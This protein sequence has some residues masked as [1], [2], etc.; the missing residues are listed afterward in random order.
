MQNNNEQQRIAIVGS[1]I[2]GL[3]CGYLLSQ[4]H[5]ITLFEANDYLGGHTHTYDVESNGKTYPVNTGFIVFNDWTYPNFIKLMDKLGVESEESDMSFS[6]RDENSGLE[7]NGTSLNSLFAQRI[8]IIRPRFL[9][10]VRDILRFNKETVSALSQQ[11]I[12]EGQTL[13]EFVEEQGYG[14]EF[15]HH[16]IVPMGSAIWSASVD[17]MMDFPLKFFLQ[18][19]NNHGML[20]VDDRPTWRVLTGGS[21]SYIDPITAPFKERIH[22]NTPVTS[23]KRHDTGVTI[24]TNQGTHEFDQVIFACHSDQALSMLSDASMDEEHILGTI[25]YQMNDVV[26]HT[27]ERLMP[28]RKLAWAAWNYHIPQRK[29][30][31]AMVTYNMNILQ[32]YQDAD[33]TFLVTLNRNQEIDPDK[34]IA[35]FRYAHPVFTLDGVASQKRHSDISGKNRTHFCGAYWL[36]GFHEDGVNSALMVCKDFGI[37]I[38]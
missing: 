21:R 9:R 38:D 30:E 16:Y 33:E 8:N 20:S 34:I 28:K 6:V 2:S 14:K 29:S 4:K 12:D 10:M 23:V 7:Y 17:V 18:F 31:Y 22:L 37:G 25:P 3:T 35:K 36:N 5:E 11:K 27:D 24:T 26:L 1:G 19:F 13:G 32:N 15:V